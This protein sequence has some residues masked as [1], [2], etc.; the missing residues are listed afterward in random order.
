VLDQKGADRYVAA[1]M[2]ALGK[3]WARTHVRYLGIHNYVDVQRHRATGTRA[4]INQLRRYAPKAKFWL[5]ETGGLVSFASSY[6]C[7]PARAA[8]RLNYLFKLA[9]QYRRFIERVYIYN[10]QGSDCRDRFDSGLV[11]ADGRP[12]KGYY[13]VKNWLKKFRH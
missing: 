3:R 10:F 11:G 2:R 6:K 9:I 13:V 8:D 4:L 5:T 7:S 12:R 1:F